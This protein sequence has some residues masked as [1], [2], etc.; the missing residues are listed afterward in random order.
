[1]KVFLS[2]SGYTSQKI[3]LALRDWLPQVLQFINP[4]VSSEDISKGARWSSDIAKELEN[5][6]FGILCVTKDNIEAP[7]LLFEAG[8]L[9]KMMDKSYVCPFIFDLKETE[10]KGP[11]LQFQYVKFEKSDIKKLLSDIN[12]ANSESPVKENMFNEAFDVWWPKLEHKLSSIK[13]EGENS[14]PKPKTSSN[15]NSEVLSEILELS[16]TNQKILRDPNLVFP[17]SYFE[18][19]VGTIIQKLLEQNNTRNRNELLHIE[20]EHRLSQVKNVMANY[21]KDLRPVDDDFENEI[22]RLTDFIR[23]NLLQ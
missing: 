23:K 18:D 15:T 2:W 3:A 13:Q 19:I 8:A 22:Y 14:K 12:S 5:S 6:S 11:I 17:K 9:S 21:K 10:V 7:W 1:M 16:R 20:I 4:Y